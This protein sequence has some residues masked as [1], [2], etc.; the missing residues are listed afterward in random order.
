M[1]FLEEVVDKALTL[2]P[3]NRLGQCLFLFPNKRA[4]LFFSRTL[5]RNPHR[6]DPLLVPEVATL[7]EWIF[8]YSGHQS[9]GW[10]TMLLTLYRSYRELAGT[11]ALSFE[12]F[13]PNGRAILNDLMELD[14]GLLTQSQ[15]KEVAMAA[16][17]SDNQSS[18][19]YALLDLLPKLHEHFNQA[20]QNQNLIHEAL[21]LR[22]LLAQEGLLEKALDAYEAVF[23]CG[24]Y[25]IDTAEIELFLQ[26][27]KQSSVH[28]LWDSD[29]YFIDQSEQEAGLL[30]KKPNLFSEEWDNMTSEIR[31]L[32]RQ[33][34]LV[35][36]QG[37][38]DQAKAMETVLRELAH[39]HDSAENTAL[40]LPHEALLLP[41][42]S[43]IPEEFN[44]INITMGYPLAQSLPVTLLRNLLD[45]HRQID[46][47]AESVPFHPL[48]RLLKN[49]E[50]APFIHEDVHE[51]L[52]HDQEAQTRS[53]PLSRALG[54]ISPFEF[55][56]TIPEN[57]QE[58]FDSL[59][60]LLDALK[61]AMP[62]ETENGQT[63]P[64][65]EL[66]Y[67]VLRQI[68]STSL[69]ANAPDIHVSIKTAWLLLWE[70]MEQGAIP[71]SG[72][73]LEG[74]QIMGMLE[75][76]CLDF[77]NLIIP[78]FNEGIFPKGG[79]A[80]SLIPHEVRV[81]FNLTGHRENDARE[82][83]HFY[84]LLKRCRRVWLIYD[85]SGRG[86]NGTEASRFIKQIE[87]ELTIHCPQNVLIKQPRV[88]TPPQICSPRIRVENNDK[89]RRHWQQMTFSPSAINTMLRC[90]LSFV[91][92]YGLKI[93]EKSRDANEID[94]R[95]IGLIAHKCLE[96]LYHPVVGQA[97]DRA[98]IHRMLP[99]IPPLV[100]RVSAEQY[101]GLDIHHGRP[102][103]EGQILQELLN[104]FL[105]AQSKIAPY[106]LQAVEQHLSAS[107]ELDN[108]T[109]FQ[110]TGF[111]DRIDQTSECW[112][113][114]D[115]KSGTIA[116]ADLNIKMMPEE[117]TFT[118]PFNRKSLAWQLL[119]YQWLFCL[120]RH[121]SPEQVSCTLLSLR[122]PN[123]GFLDIK[124][125]DKPIDRHDRFARLL[126][127]LFSFLDDPGYIFEQT[128]Q[129][130]TCAHCPY[131]DICKR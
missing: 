66:L 42:L 4:G 85:G 117:F 11:H 74:L 91:Y 104:R 16:Q 95:G 127:G 73:P 118:D 129:A 23:V 53:V 63:D 10:E 119:I 107:L 61:N 52:Q 45:L 120:S 75:S 125:S 44:R 47:P 81:K 24:F 92:R 27:R 93:Q 64:K 49:P 17:S 30:F 96:E 20:L 83:Y 22:R 72:E 68:V 105:A 71:F 124:P 15:I 28:L 99:Q 7:A 19:F 55:L 37:A 69:F 78:S 38:I 33:I 102:Y 14:R 94:P 86:E 40:I 90:P 13:Y 29:R 116:A 82:A 57:P 131:K 31:D 36:T 62:L 115:Y 5:Q 25:P 84:R 51:A 122:N 123:D 39:N 8:Q 109:R 46:D 48:Y 111:I 32:D 34:T 1:T 97:I 89:L 9:A 106:H 58:L 88:H 100:A 59:L 50:L 103:L 12:L 18:A 60:K 43:T 108:K 114:V 56:L 87:H 77:K 35:E 67:Q 70:S 41:L 79:S 98:V 65:L 21:A 113:I 54:W 126:K 80:F 6:P 2:V 101:P 112:R 3:P 26:L 130:Q 76:R 110:I 128:D 121:E